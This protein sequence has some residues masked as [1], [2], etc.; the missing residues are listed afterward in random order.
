MGTNATDKVDT[1]DVT[2]GDIFQGLDS[3]TDLRTGITGNK[4]CMATRNI[5]NPLQA[6]TYS[7]IAVDFDEPFAS[8]EPNGIGTIT[9][10]RAGND[11]F[12]SSPLIF[13]NEINRFVWI[14]DACDQAAAA[15]RPN[16]EPTTEEKNSEEDTTTG[17]S[18]TEESP[19]IDNASTDSSSAEPS[20]EA[21][22]EDSST[23]ANSVEP[24]SVESPTKESP[25]GES[26]TNAN[27]DPTTPAIVDQEPST[28]VST[29]EATTAMN[30]P[31]SSPAEASS[32]EASTVAPGADTTELNVDINI[33]L[34]III[35]ILNE[36]ALNPMLRD[37]AIQIWTNWYLNLPLPDLTDA[38]TNPDDVMPNMPEMPHVPVAPIDSNDVSSSNNAGSATATTDTLSS[39]VAASTNDSNDSKSNA[40]RGILARTGSPVIMLIVIA[41]LLAAGGG[42]LLRRKD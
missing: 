25:S 30:S 19:S 23:P 6:A 42:L 39:S 13:G 37:W 3:T 8:L 17:E 2:R 5:D 20:T 31:E 11:Y 24:T 7:S 27:T 34:D 38:I 1:V 10:L 15:L 22:G 26:A 21:T 41:I 12:L 18:T 28:A 29:P 40:Q 16:V 35:E 32:A 36:H 9:Q 33:V 14:D 4:A